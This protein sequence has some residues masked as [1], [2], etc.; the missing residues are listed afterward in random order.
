VCQ[1]AVVA[2]QFIIRHIHEDSDDFMFS[3]NIFKVA[4]RAELWK[5]SDGKLDFLKTFG[6]QRM[7][8][9]YAT[10]RVWRVF[11]LLAPSLE[12][13]PVTDSFA[14]EYPFSVKPETGKLSKE[15]LM[16]LQRDHYEGSEFDLTQGLQ[17]GPYGD[18][19][20]WDVSPV[21][22]MDLAE[23]MEGSFERAI[24]LFRTSYSFVAVSR[25]HL[26]DP[27]SSVLW[28]SQYAPASTTYTPFYVAATD[29]PR[30]YTKGSLFNYDPSVSFWNFAA[31]GNYA[32]R[33]YIHTKQVLQDLQDQLESA[34]SKESADIDAKAAAVLNDCDAADDCDK[35]EAMTTVV[36]MLTDFTH[37]KAD[38]TVQAWRDLLPKLITRFHDG[39]SAENLQGAEITMKKLFYPKWWLEAV[40]YFDSTPNR[41]PKAIMFAANPESTMSGGE[42][43][44]T[45]AGYTGGVVAAALFASALS[46]TIGFV[47]GRRTLGQR[48]EYMVIDL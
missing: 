19:E 8:S 12:L 3:K 38:Q 35:R 10:R 5:P 29:A 43:V 32:N 27:V 48:A 20:R 24:S 6:P 7:H 28:F 36:E 31:A 44:Y 47:L 42:L 22:G 34:Y 13:D 11:S 46:V 4:E 21:D 26:P 37:A 15:D 16:R 33:F 45:R 40:G 9:P 39:Y 30:A 1:V 41:D 14:S 25:K 2:N 17:A 18:P 23:V